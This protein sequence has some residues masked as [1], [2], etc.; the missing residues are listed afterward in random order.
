M[1]EKMKYK[2]PSS[3]MYDGIQVFSCG[4]DQNHAKY[5]LPSSYMNKIVT[6]T[7]Q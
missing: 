7:K 4:I 6:T 5:M 2:W 1:T 3:I